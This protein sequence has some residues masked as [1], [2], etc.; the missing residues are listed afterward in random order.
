MNG[1]L[2]EDESLD[3][4]AIVKRAAEFLDDLDVPQVDLLRYF[5]CHYDQFYT[6]VY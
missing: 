1:L 6:P 2:R 4:L 5:Y 3:K